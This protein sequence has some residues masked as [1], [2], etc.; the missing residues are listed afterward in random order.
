[1]DSEGLAMH[2]GVK[3]CVQAHAQRR[4]AHL[5]DVPEL[6]FGFFKPWLG[7]ST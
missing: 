1:M 2:G 4:A 6:L 5:C 3:L 7:A